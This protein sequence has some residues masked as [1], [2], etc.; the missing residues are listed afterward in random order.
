MWDT[1]ALQQEVRCMCRLYWLHHNEW[2]KPI[3]F[4]V[5]FSDYQKCIKICLS[6]PITIE[7]ECYFFYSF[8]RLNL[9]ARTHPIH[10]VFRN[11]ISINQNQNNL[12]YI[13]CAVCT[14]HNFRLDKSPLAA[15]RSTRL[16]S[17]MI[18]DSRFPL[19]NF[20]HFIF[21]RNYKWRRVRSIPIR[22]TLYVG[23]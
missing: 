21:D 12:E 15:N 3:L 20:H 18:H 8:F 2:W 23:V 6:M 11:I 9:M 13:A 14:V 17:M 1:N 7:V 5:E 4:V 19:C 10:Y 16:P 22:Y